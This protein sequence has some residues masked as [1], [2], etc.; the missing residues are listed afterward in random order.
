MSS[1]N[2]IKLSASKIKAFEN[3]SWAYCCKYIWKLPDEANEG[4]ARGS[5]SHTAFEVLLNER[6]K[7]EFDKIILNRDIKASKSI[8][9][10]ILKHARKLKV[11]QQDNLELINSMVLTGLS[12]DFYCDG[13]NK[14]EA[15]KEFYLDSNNFIINGFIDKKA[16]YDNK[17]VIWDY[18]SSKK[19]F[20]KEEIDYNLQNLMYSLACYKTDKLI[21]SVK[22]L[23]LRFPKN[24]VQEAPQCNKTILD[25]FESYLK[26]VADKIASFT[27][28]HAAS[29]MACDDSSKRWLC[30]KNRFKGESNIDGSLVWGC[31][32]K[33]KY[34]Y[35]ALLDKNKKVIRTSLEP[36]QTDN[37]EETVQLMGYMGCPAFAKNECIDIG[38]F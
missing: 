34:N 35:Y 26:F 2:K 9:R 3:C 37:K 33:F 24:P 10:L 7:K 17:I 15:E 36:I 8:H 16:T 22:F 29:Q 27:E 1:T 38:S 20:S 32:F 31:P 21:P 28:K 23:F 4:A 11:H 12:H 25:G 18:K 5:V 6:H 30:G 14:I 13:S 19:K